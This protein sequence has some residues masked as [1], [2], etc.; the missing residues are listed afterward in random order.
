MKAL[1]KILTS[2]LAMVIAL[3]VFSFQVF[4]SDVVVKAL[5]TYSN[6]T[7][8]QVQKV[9]VTPIVIDKKV[10][11][12]NE[13]HLKQY[14]ITKN[15]TKSHSTFCSWGTYSFSDFNQYCRDNDYELVGWNISVTGII[16]AKSGSTIGS[17]DKLLTMKATCGGIET[18]SLNIS[19]LN[20][21][22]RTLGWDVY[23]PDGTT[24]STTLTTEFLSEI[25]YLPP[26]GGVQTVTDKVTVNLNYWP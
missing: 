18:E 1:H 3:N 25:K 8:F 5:P 17:E 20:N 14:A 10:S 2:I 6:F 23:L 15:G 7:G 24:E 11:L 26:R 19:S 16:L 4:A 12:M 21:M 22:S 13:L 9:T